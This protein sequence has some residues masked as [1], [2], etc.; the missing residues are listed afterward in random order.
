MPPKTEAIVF[1]SWWGSIWF[2]FVVRGIRKILAARSEALVAKQEAEK[3][4]F[5][6]WC[7]ENMPRVRRHWRDTP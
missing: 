4:K 3:A 7:W 6:N 1:A 5:D 2:F